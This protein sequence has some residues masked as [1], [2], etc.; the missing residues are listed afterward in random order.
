MENQMLI[1]VWSLVKAYVP[2]KDKG[3]VANKFVDIIS[4]NGVDEEELRELMGHDDE[5]DEA[6]KLMIDEDEEEYED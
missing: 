2:S 6:I 3:I 1:D 4:D 5:L